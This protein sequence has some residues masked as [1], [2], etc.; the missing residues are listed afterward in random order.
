MAAMARCREGMAALAVFDRRRRQGREGGRCRGRSATAR[1]APSIRLAVLGQ[2]ARRG[3][4]Q[5]T[6]SLEYPGGR[7]AE[8]D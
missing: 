6:E 3:S 1:A 4:E 7:M 8:E 5:L 2:Q